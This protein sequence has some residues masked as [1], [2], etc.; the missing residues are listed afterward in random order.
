MT[1]RLLLWSAAALIAWITPVSAQTV[2]G[3]FKKWMAF[4]E[5]EAKGKLCAAFAEP[6]TSTYSQPIKGRDPALFFLTRFPS[7]NVR[8]EGSTALGYPVAANAKVVVQID[9]AQTFTMFAEKD[10]AWLPDERDAALVDAMR[11]G[12][13][14]IV[15]GTSRRGTVTT[16]TYSLEGVTAAVNAITKACP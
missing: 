13:E 12:D 16:D 15:R 10:T 2:L 14:M 4:A 3:E 1:G 11:K 5:K 7:K 6:S 9:D 8:T